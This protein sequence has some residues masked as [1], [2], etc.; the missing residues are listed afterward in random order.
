MNTMRESLEINARRVRQR[1]DFMRRLAD[2][3]E[4]ISGQVLSGDEAGFWDAL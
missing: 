1:T 4:G 3:L 2:S